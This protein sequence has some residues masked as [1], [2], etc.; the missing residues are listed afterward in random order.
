MIVDSP[1]SPLSF[2]P[3]FLSLSFLSWFGFKTSFTVKFA[4]EPTLRAFQVKFLLEH[5]ETNLS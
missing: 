2:L 1:S 5:G 4:F 3:P